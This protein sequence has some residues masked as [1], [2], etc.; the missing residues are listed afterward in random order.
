[1]NASLHVAALLVFVSLLAPINRCDVLERNVVVAE[2]GGEVLRQWIVWD[3]DHTEGVHR[4]QWW[5]LE[6]GEVVTRTVDGWRVSV[7]GKR[8]E[9]RTYRTTRTTHDPELCDRDTW[10]VE[11]RRKI[12]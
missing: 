4:C 1:M 7:G 9:G 5:A 10:P 3:W 12:R 6:R 2:D 8:I 11:R